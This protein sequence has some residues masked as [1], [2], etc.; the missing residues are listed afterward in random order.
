M[1][2]RPTGHVITREPEELYDI[3]A[4]PTE[5]VNRIDDPDLQE[6]AAQMRAQL[7][8]FS[9]TRPIPGWRW[10]FRKGASIISSPNDPF[11]AF[12]HLST[13]HHREEPQ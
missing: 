6:V 10:T 12:A 3:E 11:L 9:A 5:S 13:A 8:E 1:G 7:Y 2:E 4:D